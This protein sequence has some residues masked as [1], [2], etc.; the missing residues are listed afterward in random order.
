VDLRKEGLDVTVVEPRGTPG[1]DVGMVVGDGSEPGVIARADL[2]HAV[3]FVAGTDNDTTNLFLVAAARRLNPGLFVAARQNR[4]AH[5][6]GFAGRTGIL[7]GWAWLGPT[8][9]QVTGTRGRAGR[10]HRGTWPG[11]CCRTP[12][13]PCTP[14]W[15]GITRVLAGLDGIDLGPPRWL[16]L[17]V[18]GVGCTD[19]VAAAEVPALV[20]TAGRGLAGLPAVELAFGAAVVPP[21][22]DPAG[23]H[24][25]PARGHV[26]GPR[27]AAR[28]PRSAAAVGGWTARMTIQSGR[29]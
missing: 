25:G 26:Y 24:P 1:E 9:W 20:T 13:Q 21:R 5:T 18:Q 6:S 7:T 28:P 22:R 4:P 8:G 15:P 27:C 14:Q 16:H 29:T 17:T 19:R 2:A 11:S 3:G 23:G 10:R 12:R